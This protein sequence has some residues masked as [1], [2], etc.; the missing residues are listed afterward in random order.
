MTFNRCILPFKELIEQEALD[1]YRKKVPDIADQ[2]TFQQGWALKSRLLA[3][4]EGTLTFENGARDLLS[5]FTL[6]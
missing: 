3:G 2:F 5:R 4:N 1:I 6:T